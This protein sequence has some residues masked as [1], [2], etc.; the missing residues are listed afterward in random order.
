M[1]DLNPNGSTFSAALDPNCVYTLTTTTGQR[2]G[3]YPAPP[4]DSPLTLPY[5]DDYQSYPLAAQARYHYDYE[6]AFEIAN[7]TKGQG[8]CLR[9]AA[10]KSASGWGGAYLPLTFLGSSD[11]KDYSI[12]ADAYIEEAGAVSLHGRIGDIPG[13]NSD[14]PPGYT[15]RIHDDGAWELK[16]F[17]TL[18][19]HGTR[20]FAA[21]EWHNLR[22]GFHGSSI[23]GF[24]DNKPVFMVDDKTYSGGLAGLGTGWN[25]AQF[26][27]LKI[28]PE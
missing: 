13:D 7:K 24:V 5:A 20:A 10:T 23:S 26:S 6:G 8:K 18:I 22:L 27:D 9:Q 15:W 17:K 2:K 25:F 11:W 1:D 21:N 16:S 3:N 12:S 4:P 28:A 14:D 19:A